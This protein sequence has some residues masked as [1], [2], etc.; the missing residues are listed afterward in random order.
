MAHKIPTI[1]DPSACKEVD[2]ARALKHAMNGIGSRGLP[3]CDRD[4]VA[5]KKGLKLTIEFFLH[6]KLADYCFAYG[7][8]ILKEDCQ[9]YRR[10]KDKDNMVKFLMDALHQVIYDNNTV[11][12]KRIISK[13][14]VPESGRKTQAWTDITSETMF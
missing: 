8:K 2:F 1:Y 6:R 7:Q 3:A 4:T 12:S 13:E 9:D 10:R 11:I 5:G 14:F